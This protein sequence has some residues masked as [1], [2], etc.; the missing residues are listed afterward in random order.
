MNLIFERGS[1]DAPAGHALVYFR[2]GESEVYGSYLIVP[3]I[4]FDPTD[5]TP[6]ALAPLLQG[7][8]LGNTMMATPMPPL[9]QIV[10]SVEYLMALA[11]RR[12]DDLIFAGNIVVSSA[13]LLMPE[14]AE[15][16]TQYGDL[17]QQSTVPDP[18]APVPVPETSRY[19]GLSEA[20]KIRELTS[21]VGRLRDSVRT[22]RGDTEVTDQMRLLADTLPAKYRVL[23]LTRAAQRPG[24]EGQRLAELYLERCYKLLREDYLDLERIDREIDAFGD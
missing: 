11:E 6:P 23:Q 22:G 16:A 9:P 24:E 5:F 20:D 4:T 12:H 3:P 2:S 7:L 19:D 13:A 10:P 18:Q 14:I 21:L 17:Y 8:D 15:V 1:A